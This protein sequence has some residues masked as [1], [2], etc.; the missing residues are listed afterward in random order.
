MAL[1]LDNLVIDAEKSIGEQK[2]CVGMR[3]INAWVDNKKTDSVD[4][5]AYDTLLPKCGFEKISIKIKGSDV[6]PFLKDF[7][8]G[9]SVPVQFQNLTIKAFQ[10]W[11][12]KGIKI[13]AT[14][15]QILPAP[16]RG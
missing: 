5:I 16:K 10:D 9:Q 14:A 11:K 15:D 3:A 7:Q 12:T 8:A 13:S 4:S 1:G 2:F 6:A